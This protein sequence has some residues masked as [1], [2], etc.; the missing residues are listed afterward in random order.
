MPEKITSKHTFAACYDY[1]PQD[2]HVQ[3][4]PQEIP[5]HINLI[6]EAANLIFKS[7]AF[8][9]AGFLNK[10]MTNLK[11]VPLAKEV[12]CTIGA[13]SIELTTPDGDKLDGM[14]LDAQDFKKLLEKHLEPIESTRA[15]GSVV[16]MWIPKDRKIMGLPDTPVLTLTQETAKFLCFVEAQLGLPLTKEKIILNDKVNRN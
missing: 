8:L 14:Y 15:D 3:R 2:Q 9:G 13:Q 10:Y 6:N 1:G 5:F 4:M 7:F 11:Q 12:L 16:Q